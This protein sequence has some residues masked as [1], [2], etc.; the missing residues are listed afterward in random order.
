M[1]KLTPDAKYR[2]EYRS[3]EDLIKSNGGLF[4][5]G[6]QAE[7]IATWTNNFPTSKA[8]ATMRPYLQLPLADGQYVIGIDCQVEGWQRGDNLVGLAYICDGR[9]IVQKVRCEYTYDDENC[10]LLDTITRWS[11]V[12]VA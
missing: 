5:S 11:R 1:A 2:D 10:T 8:W 7:Y 4:K 9:G 12:V 3:L 6:R